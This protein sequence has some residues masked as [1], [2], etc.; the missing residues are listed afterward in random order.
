MGDAQEMKFSAP[1]GAQGHPGVF[2]SEDAFVQ[3]PKLSA[4]TQF[5]CQTRSR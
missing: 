2:V 1:P 3:T 4:Y 5:F